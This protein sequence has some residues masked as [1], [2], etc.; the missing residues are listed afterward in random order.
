[1]NIEEILS[2]MDDV[3]DKAVAVPFSGKK[4]LIDVEIMNNLIHE[5]RMSLPREIEE[6]REVV[7]T[8]KKLVNEAKAEAEKIIQRAEELARKM[9][10]SQEIV[11]LAQSRAEEIM[12]NAQN[13]S[14]ELHNTTKDYVDNMLAKT[15]EL[16]KRNYEDVKKARM[17]LKGVGK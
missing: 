5:T 1:M 11:R 13:K 17:A 7:A 8:R 6:A 16:N 14:K 3:L 4:S 10:A 12:V 15:E 9:V 2:M